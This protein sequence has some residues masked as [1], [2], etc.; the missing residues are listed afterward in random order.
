MQRI[1]RNKLFP[2]FILLPTIFFSFAS[3]NIE[4][5]KRALKNDLIELSD[6]KYGV[7]NVDVWRE[8]IVV[9]VNKKIDEFQL[10]KTDREAARKKIIG[11]LETSITDFEDTYRKKNNFLKNIGASLFGIF[12]E[13][14]TEA[15]TIADEVLLFF[16]NEEN[17]DGVKTYFKKQLD[18]YS[19]KTFQNIDYSGRDSI[20]KKYGASSNEECKSLLT[21]E[22][23]SLNKQSAF[24]ASFIAGIFILVIFSVFLN[25][26]L[27]PLSISTYISISFLFLVLGLLLPMIDI[28]ARINSMEFQLLGEP[29]IFENQILYY[30]SKSILEMAKLMLSQGNIKVILV[31]LLVLI[32]SVV[33]PLMKLI[34]TLLH[35]RNYKI[36]NSKFFNFIVFKSGKWSMA[37]VMVVS[38]FMTYIGFDGILTSQ[39]SDLSNVSDK[40]NIITTNNSELQNGFFF[41]LGFVLLSLCISSIL[42]KPKKT[43]HH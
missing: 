15:P 32:F 34:F 42:K 30:K 10:E 2:L 5:N 26:N 6:V 18:E 36:T 43:S 24:Y 28:D 13:L 29:I 41:F 8:K 11:F 9:I 7:F 40:V 14:K 22:I 27:S 19:S 21:D 12:D 37:D 35:S 31:G 23:K 39:L 20:F 33:F 1:F 17:S 16:E 3:Y 25:S 4:S 38:I